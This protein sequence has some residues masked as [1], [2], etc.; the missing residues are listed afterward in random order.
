MSNPLGVTLNTVRSLPDEIAVCGVTAGINVLSA[1]HL[2]EQYRDDGD[3][4]AGIVGESEVISEHGG[5]RPAVSYECLRDLN[6]SAVRKHLEQRELQSEV[7]RVISAR[8]WHRVLA[9]AE[10]VTTG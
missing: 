10:E 5:I 2:R 9:D 4:F 8:S 7:E 6:G 1:A 3:V